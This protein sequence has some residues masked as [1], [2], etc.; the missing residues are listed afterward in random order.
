MLEDE[1][2]FRLK[3]NVTDKLTELF[4]NLNSELSDIAKHYLSV[5][6]PEALST[7]GKISKGENYLGFPW[8]VLD[9][10]RYFRQDDVFAYRSLCWWAHEFSFTIHLSGIYLNT[11]TSLHQK[12]LSLWNKQLYICVG[13]TP[14]SYHFNNDNYILLDD[15]LNGEAPEE[16]IRQFKFLKLSRRLPLNEIE[17]VRTTAIA[18][19]KLIAENLYDHML[20]NN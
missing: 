16:K 14:W 9:Y 5:L 8:I 11:I 6:P 3:K 19:F 4:G 7:T 10:P 12:L 13:N 20:P 15:F 1:M 18:N 17:K 2:I